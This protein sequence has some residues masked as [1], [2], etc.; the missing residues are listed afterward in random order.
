MSRTTDISCSRSERLS[1]WT[2]YLLN[3]TGLICVGPRSPCLPRLRSTYLIV[4]SS[5]R[6]ERVST[7]K[8][9]LIMERGTLQSRP[10]GSGAGA[11]GGGGAAGGGSAAAGIAGSGALGG[12]GLAATS[13]AATGSIAQVVA[14]THLLQATKTERTA[15]A[16]ATMASNCNTVGCFMWVA[17]TELWF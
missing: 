3:V 8:M 10:T 17:S 13:T 5:R 2:R 15:A 11:G 4:S 16:I 14:S 6:T 1:P 9:P 7:F 12:A